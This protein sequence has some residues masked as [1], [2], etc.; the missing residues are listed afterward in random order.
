MASQNVTSALLRL[1][2]APPKI[3]GRPAVRPMFNTNRAQHAFPKGDPSQ[4]DPTAPQWT[5]FTSQ[6]GQCE[7]PPPLQKAVPKSAI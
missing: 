3:P 5:Q 2:S 1:C 4:Q 6:H 7:E